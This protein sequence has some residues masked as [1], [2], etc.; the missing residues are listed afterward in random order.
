VRKQLHIAELTTTNHPNI[1]HHKAIDLIRDHVDSF[2]LTKP[3]PFD[4]NIVD[5]LGSGNCNIGC[6][7]DKKLSMLQS[8]LPDAQALYEHRAKNGDPK[9]GHLR[10]LDECE[11]HQLRT[12]SGKPK[13]VE[14][15]VVRFSDGR[16]ARVKADT[17]VVAA[18]AIGSSKLL[19]RSGIKTGR[20]L[21]FNMIT[22]VFA[23]FDEELNSYDAIQMGHYMN[24][25]DGE[26]ILET[27]F[28]PPVGLSTAMGGWF[29]QHMLNMQAAGR[30]VAYG[31]VVG[32]EDNGRVLPWSLSGAS[33]D[34]SPIKRDLTKMMRGMDT[35]IRMLLKA[36]A[37]RVIVNTWDNLVFT[38]ER[39]LTQLPRVV[40]DP[41]FLTVAS[42]HPQ[43]GNALGK[44]LDERFRVRG[45]ENLHVADASVFPS[46]VQVNPQMTVMALA[47]YA[48]E[49]ME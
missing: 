15:L 8:I 27:W 22:P 9:P 33:F 6:A 5:C 38:R 12:R 29:G 31:V 19:M 46:S 24:D 18:G 41:R 10:I 1:R 32:T 21:S 23:E 45:Y 39:D 26:F 14:D 36:G 16:F 47:R 48:G 43:G 17:F 25:K 20:G 28:S 3:R 34:F 2:P 35:L 4:A 30:M 13:R 11:A 37:R 7:W 44:L 42:S 40:E 49:R